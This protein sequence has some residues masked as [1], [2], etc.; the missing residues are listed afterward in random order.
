MKSSY[1]TILLSLILVACGSNKKP[2]L[3]EIDNTLATEE[4]SFPEISSANIESILSSIPHPL[5]LA[6][7]VQESG[8][9]YNSAY[10]NSTDNYSNYNTSNKK[11]L[12]LGIYGAD[13]GY[14]NIYSQIQDGLDYLTVVSKLSDDLNIGQ[15]LD[16]ESL[17]RLTDNNSNLDSLLMITSQN[18]DR[19]NG[20]FVD[21]NN[22][23]LST[24]L[25][26]GGWLEALHITNQVMLTQMDNEDLRERIGEQKIV[27]DN[28]VLLLTVY[29]EHD[30]QI[31]DLLADMQRLEEA[32]Q[33]VTISYKYE[34]STSEIVDGVLEIISNS[35]SEV[36]ITDD[37]ITKISAIVEE[38][39]NKIIG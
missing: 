38:V 32:Y 31:A 2:D 15:F 7:H 25:L 28:I 27:L 3:A 30:A 24:L 20:H 22:A 18:F 19:I 1:Y 33:S 14:T 10:L 12:N 5:E 23:S 11:A 26:T 9:E 29:S 21:Q 8:I 6:V 13:L 35:T 34:E 17:R 39:R 4:A 36:S 37:D 16:F